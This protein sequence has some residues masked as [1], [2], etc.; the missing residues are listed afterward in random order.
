[1]GARSLYFDAFGPRKLQNDQKNGASLAGCC[2]FNKKDP[3]KNDSQGRAGSVYF[4]AFGPLKLQN[5]DSLAG[6]CVFNKVIPRAGLGV[7]IFKLLG[8]ENSKRGLSRKL[9]PL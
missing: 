1:M 6:C 4:E 8:R 3:P 2:L 9:L 7:S 5:G